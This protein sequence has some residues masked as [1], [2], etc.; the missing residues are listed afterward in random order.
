MGA[1]LP[2]SKVMVSDGTF[3]R[4]DKLEVGESIQTYVESSETHEVNGITYNNIGTYESSTVAT[5]TSSSLVS[6]YK[7]ANARLHFLEE[8]LI[9]LPFDTENVFDES[10]F[11]IDT[12]FYTNQGFKQ[13][14]ADFHL[15]QHLILDSLNIPSDDN[16]GYKAVANID[17]YKTN[18]VVMPATASAGDDYVILSETPLYTIETTNGNPYIVSN[19]IIK[20]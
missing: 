7:T 15:S 13:I 14:G 8:G 10:K 5:I 20:N 1:F 9:Y 19:F 2:S 3:K 18:D 11:S 17:F 4:I 6:D 16:S 12:E